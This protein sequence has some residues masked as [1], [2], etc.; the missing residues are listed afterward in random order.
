MQLFPIFALFGAVI[1]PFFLMRYVHVSN[2][3]Y[4]LKLFCAICPSKN[5][6]KMAAVSQLS[7]LAVNVTV[8][9]QKHPKNG[10]KMCHNMA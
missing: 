8:K 7:L 4:R 6:S 1:A 9:V 2:L 5:N 10:T 3:Y